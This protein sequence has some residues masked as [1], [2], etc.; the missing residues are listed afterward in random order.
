MSCDVAS[1]RAGPSP[2]LSDAQTSCLLALLEV[3]KPGEMGQED[4]AKQSDG[5]RRL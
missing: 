2:L 3:R 4:T 1:P 5:E